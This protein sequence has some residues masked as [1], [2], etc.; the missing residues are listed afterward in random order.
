MTLEVAP[1]INTL[2]DPL[3]KTMPPVPRILCST[4][5]ESSFQRENAS[6]RRYGNDSIELEVE[7]T[8]QQLWAT[9]ASK[10]A[11]KEGSYSVECRLR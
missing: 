5:L 8:T 3:A 9:Y 7:I 1:L 10:S 4:G 11:G 2:S 6:A